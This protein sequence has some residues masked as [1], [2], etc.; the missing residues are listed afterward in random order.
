MRNRFAT[1][2]RKKLASS[3]GVTQIETGLWRKPPQFLSGNSTTQVKFSFNLFRKIRVK[4]WN[5]MTNKKS[6]WVTLHHNFAIILSENDFHLISRGKRGARK[7]V[8]G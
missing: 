3:A 1:A 5:R 7:L 6:N 2:G 8:V 4:K